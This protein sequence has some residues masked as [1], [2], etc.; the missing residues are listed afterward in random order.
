MGK[1]VY[2]VVVDYNGDFE[3]LIA[4]DFPR[5]MARDN[6]RLWANAM[7]RAARKAVQPAVKTGYKLGGSNALSM[8]VR[9]F[10]WKKGQAKTRLAVHIGA[11][12]SVKK[13]LVQW[14]AYYNKT[15]KPA[16]FRYGIRHAHLVEWGHNIRNK[17]GGPILGRV[18]GKN[19]L[20]K[21]FRQTKGRI[22]PEFQKAIQPTIRTEFRRL[23][24]Q[25]GRRR[26]RWA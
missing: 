21:A 7:K 13:A 2:G 4:R 26:K 10:Q 17:K 25:S 14:L 6:N 23:A 24:K 9:T 16:T 8:A 11:R 19:V 5:I 15:P 22:A 20:E 1:E 12:R 3:K 18:A